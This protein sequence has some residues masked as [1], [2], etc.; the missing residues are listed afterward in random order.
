[1][2]PSEDQLLNWTSQENEKENFFNSLKRILILPQ[3]FPPPPPKPDS[4]PEV[5]FYFV[6]ILFLSTYKLKIIYI[7]L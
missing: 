7:N 3:D 5:F 4:P 1:M 2:S 6:R